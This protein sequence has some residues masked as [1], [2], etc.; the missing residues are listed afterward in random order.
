MT[1]AAPAP[2]T[3]AAALHRLVAAEA[4]A[5]VRRTQQAPSEKATEEGKGPARWQNQGQ[6]LVFFF[7]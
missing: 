5:A 2:V 3:P 1:P 7:Y 6:E 4:E